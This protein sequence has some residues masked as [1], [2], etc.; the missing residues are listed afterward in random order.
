MIGLDPTGGADRSPSGRTASRSPG[1]LAALG[2]FGGEGEALGA[3]LLGYVQ[4]V[5]MEHL[6]HQSTPRPEW[7]EHDVKLFQQRY[8]GKL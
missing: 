4:D 7:K 6:A 1:L 3:G 2:W 5:Y 8:A